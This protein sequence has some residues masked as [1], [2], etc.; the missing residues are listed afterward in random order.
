[1]EEAGLYAGQ[2]AFLNRRIKGLV[3]RLDRRRREHLGPS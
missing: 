1:M 2:L 3:E